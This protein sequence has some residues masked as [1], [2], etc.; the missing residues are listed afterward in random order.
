MAVP[1]EDVGGYDP[2]IHAETEHLIPV[3]ETGH[4]PLSTCACEPLRAQNVRGGTNL[5]TWLHR[6]LAVAL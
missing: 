6:T 5:P 4:E 1:A 2:V 3:G